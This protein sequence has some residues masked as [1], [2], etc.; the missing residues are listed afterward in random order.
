MTKNLSWIFIIFLLL[1]GLSGCNTIISNSAP[2]KSAPLAISDTTKD[3]AYILNCE[4]V[5]TIPIGNEINEF[6]LIDPNTEWFNPPRFLFIDEGNHLYLDDQAHG[7]IFIYDENYN[8]ASIVNIPS[9]VSEEAHYFPLPIWMGMVVTNDRIFL[10]HN[11]IFTNNGHAIITVHNMHGA[12]LAIIDITEFSGVAEGYLND[13][14][15]SWDRIH[16]YYDS[17][18][19]VIFN[20]LSFNYFHVNEN[21][22]LN[23]VNLN[24]EEHSYEYNL[25]PGH[26]GAIYYW[27]SNQEIYRL[28]VELNQLGDSINLPDRLTQFGTDNY[29]LYGVDR[30]GVLYFGSLI[31]DYD[32][33]THIIG[34]YDP[35]SEEIWVASITAAMEN[36]FQVDLGNIEIAPDGTIY[37]FD[38]TNWPASRDLL[39]CEFMPHP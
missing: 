21:F 34:R 25:T 15:Y 20:A 23:T 31:G 9:Y 26:D 13:V 19:S 28:N 12:E 8:L 11:T 37:T 39:R 24:I 3:F 16:L 18:D 17:Q 1:P 4:S 29:N 7:R 22:E 10:L 38:D 30:S 2:L 35:Q 14:I 33:G 5:I 36:G 32:T 6:G 27:H